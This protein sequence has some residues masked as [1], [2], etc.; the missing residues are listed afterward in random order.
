MIVI[1]DYGT[2]NLG[3]I[4]NMLKKIGADALISSDIST[5][6][7]ADKLILP[8]VGSFDNAMENLNN[9]GLPHI[10][11]KKVIKEKTYI[12]GICLGIQ[13]F[14]E[15]SAE[16]NLPG[17]GWIEGETIKFKLNKNQTTLKIPHMRWNTVKIK[18]NSLLFKNMYN[19]ARFYFVHSYHVVCDNEQDIL[20][21]TCHGYDFVSAIQKE[22]IIGVQFHPEKS[23][24]FGM[25]ILQNFAELS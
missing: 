1:V 13:L 4:H 11:K 2:G 12:L 9:L 17:L 21:M 25:K 10:L 20:S 6:E 7:N 8:G 3:S 24:K 18:K 15:R 19:D 5:I 23:H 22:N 16:G 14:T